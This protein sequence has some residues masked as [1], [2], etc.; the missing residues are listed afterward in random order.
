MRISSLERSFLAELEKLIWT[1][2]R[3]R[4]LAFIQW[5]IRQKINSFQ[6][7]PKIPMKKLMNVLKQAATQYTIVG[8]D[9]RIL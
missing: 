5:Y 8:K 7:S 2:A 1:Q 4:K 6:T 9:M 3:V